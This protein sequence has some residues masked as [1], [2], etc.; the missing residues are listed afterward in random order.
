ML[1]VKQGGPKPLPTPNPSWH[2]C[3]KHPYSL[4][5]YKNNHRGLDSIMFR[6]RMS[7]NHYRHILEPSGLKLR[8]VP[9][10]SDPGFNLTKEP[11]FLNLFNRP[12][13]DRLE[14]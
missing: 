9:D 3:P 14:T 5:N 10:N 6:R 8:G 1:A 7:C 13:D 11:D 2:A 12:I 4:E